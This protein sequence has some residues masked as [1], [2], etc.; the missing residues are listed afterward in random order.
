MVLLS[1]CLRPRGAWAAVPAGVAIVAVLGPYLSGVADARRDDVKARATVADR[2]GQYGPAARARLRPHFRARGVRYPPRKLVLVG[3]KQEK[4][5]EAYA[6]D[7]SGKPVFVRS[8]PILAASGRIGPKLREGDLQVPEGVYRIALL[9]PNSRFH[10]S[11][12]INYPNESDRRQARREG[13]TNLGRDIM[14]HGGGASIGCLAMGDEAAE[15]LFVLAA[16]TGLGNITV[17]LSPVDFRVRGLPKD[18]PELPA[19]TDELYATIRQRMAALP[20]RP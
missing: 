19:W 2:L 1:R 18:P 20:P 11:L 3:L 9:N 12:G 6:A 17:I 14:I 10:L 7:A 16:E 13:R 5:L 15:D 4:L 8:Y